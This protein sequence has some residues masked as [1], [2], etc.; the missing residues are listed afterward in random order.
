MVKTSRDAII[1]AMTD[2]KKK[3]REKTQEK[4]RAKKSENSRF[5]QVP[6]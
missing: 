1:G 6:L 3:E 4:K 2:W 5:S